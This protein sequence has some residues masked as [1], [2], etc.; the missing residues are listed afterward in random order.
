MLR[1]Q[2]DLLLPATLDAVSFPGIPAQITENHQ[3][4][5]SAQ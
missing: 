3:E 4:S 2:E 5:S 1:A